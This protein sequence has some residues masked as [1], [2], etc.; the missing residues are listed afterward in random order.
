MRLV[1]KNKNFKSEEHIEMI[2]NNNTKVME[3][4]G[5]QHKNPIIIDENSQNFEKV[6]HF[7]QAK[8]FRKK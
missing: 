5:N 7:V 8:N 1:K 6:T 3:Q 4:Y 2:I